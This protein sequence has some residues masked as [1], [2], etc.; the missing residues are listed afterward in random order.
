MALS[1]ELQDA[2]YDLLLTL[3]ADQSFKIVIAVAYVL[4]YDAIARIFGTG[5]GSS[6]LSV[7]NLSVQYL[8]RELFVNEVCYYHGFLSIAI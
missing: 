7:Y 6:K 2:V 3:M 1:K 8:N 4:S 5:L